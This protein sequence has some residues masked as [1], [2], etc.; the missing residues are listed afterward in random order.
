MLLMDLLYLMLYW[1][2]ADGPGVDF[3]NQT[4]TG[5]Y[6]AFH[7]VK[8][9]NLALGPQFP[10]VPQNVQEG[11]GKHLPWTGPMIVVCSP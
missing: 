10:V 5:G 1:T 9:K 11:V 7:L 6:L 4:L 3:V 2:F 8:V